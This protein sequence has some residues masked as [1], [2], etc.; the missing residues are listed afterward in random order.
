[1][2]S[3]VPTVATELGSIAHNYREQAD[4]TYR[5]IVGARASRV[6]P[7]HGRLPANSCIGP[8]AASQFEEHQSE[9]LRGPGGA[10]GRLPVRARRSDQLAGGN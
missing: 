3:I 6:P 5:R 7:P 10:T 8:F 1:M 4:F 2:Y 9:A